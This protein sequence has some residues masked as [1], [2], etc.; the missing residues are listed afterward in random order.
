MLEA[1][2]LRQ[3]RKCTHLQD[4]PRDYDR[5]PLDDPRRCYKELI[6]AARRHLHR[7]RIRKHCDAMSS[8]IAGGNALASLSQ[9]RD[10]SASGKADKGDGKGKDKDKNPVAKD[11]E[12]RWFPE[13]AQDRPT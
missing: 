11:E 2:F 13:Y 1:L 7:V 10:R 8:A 12:F 4:E 3:L 5:F 9:R 6:A